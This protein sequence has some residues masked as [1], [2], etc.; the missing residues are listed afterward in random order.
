[1][2][3]LR[4]LVNKEGKTTTC[5]LS[6]AKLTIIMAENVRVEEQDERQD[7]WESSE[8]KAIL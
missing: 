6:Y 1:M 7:S 4:L 3:E 8:S 5:P 2:L